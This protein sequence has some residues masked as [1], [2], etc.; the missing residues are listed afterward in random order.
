MYL[1]KINFN[2]DFNDYWCNQLI[3]KCK[4]CTKEIILIIHYELYDYNF[5]ENLIKGCPYCGREN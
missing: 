2:E 3:Y 5:S 4:Y 1:S